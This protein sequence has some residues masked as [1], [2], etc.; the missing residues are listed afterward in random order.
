MES[1][2]ERLYVQSFDNTDQGYIHVFD[3]TRELISSFSLNVS[4][5]SGYYL[6]FI[7][8]DRQLRL[9]SFS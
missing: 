6:D 4:A 3:T 7:N 5:A 8:D 2:E 9:L 1:Y